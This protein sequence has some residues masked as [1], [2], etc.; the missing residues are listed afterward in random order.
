LGG[1]V[2]SDRLLHKAIGEIIQIVEKESPTR[3]ILDQLTPLL[4]FEDFDTLIHDI[5]EL[6][7]SCEKFK[8]TTIITVGEPVGNQAARILEFLSSVTTAT[9]KLFE[10]SPEEKRSLSLNARL[11]HYPDFYSSPF[12]IRTGI[13]LT[14]IETITPPATPSALEPVI[15][16]QVAQQLEKAE[17]PITEKE[18]VPEIS[19]VKPSE[20]ASLEIP[21]QLDEAKTVETVPCK[22]TPSSESKLLEAD[23]GPPQAFPEYPIRDLDRDDFTGL[24]NFDGLLHIITQAI[25]Q[26]N[27][28]SLMTVAIIKGV[29]SR[30]KRLL[31]SHKLAS[32]VKA[33]ID[34]PA[35]VGRYSDK[36]I[37][38]LDKTHK[39]QSQ[40]IAAM[41]KNKAF[42]TLTTENESLKD[43]E[44]V[45]DVYTYPEDIR[46]IREVETIVQTGGEQ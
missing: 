8:A 19:I 9:I 14:G 43:L 33:A 22:V 30:A 37:V 32:A 26:K 21:G 18:T 42:E 4:Q 1:Q 41:V 16:P 2:E 7:Y 3:L 39:P 36:I 5:K 46:T 13:G 6:I 20:E 24:F 15:T 25:E 23:L 17:V 34:K 28:F 11:G 35:P 31:L 38:F 44:I 27:P 45:V 12:V 40:A 29:D 10:G